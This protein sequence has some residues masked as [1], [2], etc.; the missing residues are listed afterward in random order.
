VKRNASRE[1]LRHNALTFSNEFRRQ[2]DRGFVSKGLLD[3]W[4]E[5]QLGGGTARLHS[6]AAQLFERERNV[7]FGGTP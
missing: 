3:S 5:C 7:N 2:S 6:L 4:S 1:G